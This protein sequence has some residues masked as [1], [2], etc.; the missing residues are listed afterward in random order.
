MPGRSSLTL[1]C[2]TSLA[3]ACGGSSGDDDNPNH[4][5]G[6]TPDA[7]VESPDAAPPTEVACPDP[8]PEASEGVCDF[9]PGSNGAVLIRGTV[10]G[11]A[12]T[13]LDGAVLV[14]TD[15]NI[16]C[17]GCDCAEDPLAADAAR[18]D[19][20]AGTISPGLINP[21]EHMTFSENP[22][23]THGTTR[24]DHRHGWR[25]SIST[26]QNPHGTG[27]L[28]NGTRWVEIRNVMG[29]VTS[30]VGSG[31]ANGMVRNLDRGDAQRLGLPEPADFDTFP[32]GDSGEQFRDNCN[33]N[34]TSSDPEIAEK[35]AYLPHVAEGIN[36]YA[37]EEFR[38]Q[39]SSFLGRDYTE[40]NVAHI[41]AIGLQ[42]SDYLDMARGGTQLIWSARSN[43][44]LYGMTAQV[45]MFHRF[46]G[47]IAL[48]TDWSYS[49]S[50]HSGRELACANYFNQTHLDG[51]FTDRDLWE[52][53]TI[54]AAIAAGAE[55]RIGSLEEG[56]AAD[57]TV[58]AGSDG[59]RAVVDAD[60]TD[61]ALVLQDG[62]PL[63][64]E[65]DVVAG[66]DPGCLETLDVCGQTRAIC[67]G[68]EFG[69]TYA[70]IAADAESVYPAF[71]CGTPDNEPSCIPSR[72][73]Q[74]DGIVTADDSDGD[75]IANDSDNCP[76]VFNP[77]RP[78]D[79]GA[80]PDAD[81]DGMGD[82][83]DPQPLVADVD[84]DSIA[85]DDDNCPLTPNSDQADTDMDNKGD[86]CDFC[87]EQSNPLTACPP[88]PPT[89]ARIQDIQSG[90]VAIGTAVTIE[91]V[92]VTGIGSADMTVQDPSPMGGT[93]ANSGVRVFVPG[94]G[95]PGNIRVGS[96]V[97]VQGIVDEFFDDTEIEASSVTFVSEGGV[98]TPT[99]V[100]V[101][102]AASE[103][104]EGVLVTITDGAVTNESF[105]CSITPPCA[106]SNLWEIGGPTG[107]LVFDRYY[108]DSDFTSRIGEL[109]VTGVMMYRFERRR[110]MPRT[111]ADFGP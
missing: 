89:T 10:L 51:Y 41:H 105:D 94:G 86:A 25:G 71:F 47:I 73:G 58:F 92:V 50:I 84:G 68:S 101:A 74:Y 55:S 45:T 1:A 91:D 67:A 22:P 110:I 80:Q 78:I 70:S 29:G 111:A 93:T 40:S 97:T 14:G 102:E 3:I 106:D 37:A 48:G 61:I 27:T 104:Y 72:P 31:A 5:A 98:L 2:L 34:Y 35:L 8:V 32:L 16:A 13:F 103:A 24:Y 88:A 90:G 46:G 26:P 79:G 63:Y 21:H 83:C 4:D 38:C 19:C 18:V 15:G 39:S 11:S 66:I 99:P 65:A 17:V 42:A 44:D 62:G 56:K 49:G 100:T 96:V 64:G 23:A 54:N 57:I 107:V 28:S 69:A 77:V 87:P 82:P 75:G 59:Y 95:P 85:N 12:Q 36:D 7:G 6:Q 53:V 20:G 76:R 30:M 43:I 52:M 60:T 81:G 109:P 33:W 9:T 108:A